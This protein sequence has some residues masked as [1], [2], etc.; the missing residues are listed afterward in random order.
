MKKSFAAILVSVLFLLG[1]GLVMLYSASYPYAQKASLCHGD[2]YWFVKR[3][4]VWCVIGI[5]G[6]LS[7]PK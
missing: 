4:A 6:L 5:I 1:L 7:A 2:L 3:Q